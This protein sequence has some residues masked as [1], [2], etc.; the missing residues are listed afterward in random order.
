MNIITKEETLEIKGGASLTGALLTQI[1][2][3]F[4][5]IYDLGV[6]L[7]GSIRRLTSNQTCSL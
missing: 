3:G 4:Q 6:S 7:G 1:L 2:K 5:F